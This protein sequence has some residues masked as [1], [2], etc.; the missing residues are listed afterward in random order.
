MP[1]TL[2]SISLSS[3]QTLFGAISQRILDVTIYSTDFV[4]STRKNRVKTCRFSFS[5][6]RWRMKK[7]NVRVH[8]ILA[9]ISRNFVTLC[10][11][12]CVVG[13]SFS[14]RV[15]GWFWWLLQFL[16]HRVRV[17]CQ[18]HRFYTSSSGSNL[19]NCKATTQTSAQ[20]LQKAAPKIGSQTVPLSVLRKCRTEVPLFLG[21]CNTSWWTNRLAANN[22]KQMFQ[23]N[24]TLSLCYEAK[25][26]WIK[27]LRSCE[28]QQ[29]L[30]NQIFQWCEVMRNT[31]CWT[32][33]IAARN[34]AKQKFQE[35][36]S[37]WCEV[38]CNSSCKTKKVGVR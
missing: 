8:L 12:F 20:F 28:M 19:T 14:L 7:K 33:C 36:T 21:D 27:W 10:T 32:K 22:T 31:S 30:Q 6:L 37:P 9:A 2:S 35:I 3:T 16:V 15:I 23:R 11:I 18:L 26:D 5:P 17:F 24:H 1:S 38:G 13:V 29:V 25:Y 34:D 4:E